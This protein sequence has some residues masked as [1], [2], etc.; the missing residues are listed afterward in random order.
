MERFY[1]KINDPNY[2][3]ATFFAVCRGKVQEQ[4]SYPV[5]TLFIAI[6]A[7]T[8]LYNCFNVKLRVKISVAH[9]LRFTLE[10]SQQIHAAWLQLD[11]TVTKLLMCDDVG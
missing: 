4:F 7:K 1:E 3:A 5:Q 8:K 9:F 11:M 6:S 2:N 10:L